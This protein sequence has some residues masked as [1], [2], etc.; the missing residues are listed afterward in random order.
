M[1]RRREKNKLSRLNIARISVFRR[2]EIVFCKIWV[3]MNFRLFSITFTLVSCAGLLTCCHYLPANSPLPLTRIRTVAGTKDVRFK[4]VFG[5]AVDAA[6]AV[7]FSDGDT[8]KIWKY[9]NNQTALLTDKLDTPSGLAYDEKQNRLIVVDAGTSTVKAVNLTDGDVSL[10][11]GIENRFGWLDG[12]AQNAIFNAPLGIAVDKDGK[13]YVADTYNNKIRYIA[14][15]KVF[16][17]PANFNLPGGIAVAPDNALIIADSENRKIERLDQNGTLTTLAGNGDYAANDGLAL[18][19]SFIEP[20]AVAINRK[21]VIYVADAGANVIRVLGGKTFFT[22]ETLAGTSSG[23]VDGSLNEAK[24]IRP[25]GLAIGRD[26]TLFV[27]DAGNAVLRAIEPENAEIGENVTPETVESLRL[28]ADELKKAGEPRWT[29]NPPNRPRDIAGTFGEI[30]GEIKQPTEFAR[31]H[32]GLDIANN[33]GE[34]VYLLRSEKILLPQA[35]ENVGGDRELIR[36]PTI[37]YIHLRL[38]RDINEKSFGDPA[39]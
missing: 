9:S 3:F 32:N 8:G 16:S 33:Y 23:L 6:G 7:Y 1:R 17:F 22:V 39:I 29:F 21:G 28:K 14:D 26:G 20:L 19:A 30:R 12:D 5:V 10:I 11:A 4:E 27:A 15:G 35:I 37:G 18:K 38:G 2:F 24:F 13:I 34:A 25:S 31:F 36:F